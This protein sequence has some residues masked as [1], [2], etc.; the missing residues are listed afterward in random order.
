MSK[1]KA[2]ILNLGV[3]YLLLRSCIADMDEFKPSEAFLVVGPVDY[4]GRNVVSL[5]LLVLKVA[6][7]A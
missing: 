3:S 2:H 7:L 1:Y 6:L 4:G 5:N